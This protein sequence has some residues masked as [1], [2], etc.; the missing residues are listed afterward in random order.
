MKMRRMTFFERLRQKIRDEIF[1]KIGDCNK[2]S[3][4]IPKHCKG[5]PEYVPGGWITLKTTQG[6]I[7]IDAS[8]IIGLGRT[9]PDTSLVMKGAVTKVYIRGAEDEPW[10]AYDSIDEIIEKIKKA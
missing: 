6:A 1:F 10:F 3:P 7:C 8:K 4:A 9:N 2:R 5:T